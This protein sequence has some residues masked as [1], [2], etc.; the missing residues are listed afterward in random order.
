MMLYIGDLDPEIDEN[1]FDSTRNEALK[2]LH[3]SFLSFFFWFLGIFVCGAKICNFSNCNLDYK[4]VMNFCA[5]LV[6]LTK[7]NN[8][9]KNEFVI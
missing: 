9:G 7:K 2:I 6:S 8:K 1:G 5:I 3:V 4:C